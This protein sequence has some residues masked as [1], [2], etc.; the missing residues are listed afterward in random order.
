MMWRH[1]DVLIASVQA[2]P[3]SARQRRDVTLARG[4]VTG[5]SHRVEA[6]VTADLWEIDGQLFLRV[7][8]ESARIVHDEHKPITLPRG[9][10]RVWMQ[11][12]Y[13]PEA[14]RPVRD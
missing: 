14:I 2:I 1:G 9:E 13:S 3:A 5:H 12:E 6:P 11:R 8:A 7:V 4:E 10:Y